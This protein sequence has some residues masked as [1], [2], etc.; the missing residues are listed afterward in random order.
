MKRIG[1]IAGL[2]LLASMVLA[3]VVWGV[4]RAPTYTSYASGD[5]F[6]PPY[7]SD[8]DRMGVAGSMAYY[9]ATLK[10]GWY[11]DWTASANPL[12][13]GGTE[14]ARTLYFNI[15]TPV[16]TCGGYR[17]PAAQRS[18]VVESIT[19][20]ALIDNLRANPGALWLIGNEPD[21]IYNG[22]PIMPELY[23]ELYHEFYTFI[24][25]YDPAAR[26]AIGA[27]VQPSPLR[28]QYLDKVLNRYE[29]LYGEK[30]PADVWNIHLYILNEGLCFTSWGATIPPG[31][32]SAGWYVPFT[33]AA[34]LNV[35]AMRQN[36]MAFR[37][38]M[39][40]RGYHARPLII[41]EFGV[42]PP[43]SYAGFE[44]PVAAQFLTDMFNM[45]LTA[46]DPAVGYAADG[47]R[48]VQLW[49]WYSVRDVTHNYGG[50]LVYGNGSLTPVGVAF[51]NM[52]LNHYTLA[53]DVY[54]VPLITP[55]LP[56]SG[57]DP[58]AVTL[59]VQVDNRGNTAAM[60]VP[61]QFKQY[62]I[63]SGAV[64]SSME[65]T[66]SQVLA[67]YAGAQPQ[68]SQSW[69]VTPGD[70]R[71]FIFEIDPGHTISQ[72]RRSSQVLAYPG[73]PDLI[74]SSLTAG[75]PPA[76]LWLTPIT[77]TVTATIRNT[78]I[79]TS[80]PA[81]LSLD[82]T[83]PSGLLRQSKFVL[84]LAPG[85]SADVTATLPISTSGFYTVSAAIEYANPES[86]PHNNTASRNILA[87][88]AQVY[89]PVVL[90]SVP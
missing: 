18:D 28:L 86:N 73:T 13:P 40:D 45:L 68:V 36:L 59:T 80:S 16:G 32:D 51:A 46:T 50:D 87:A 29:L 53:A 7:P 78:G 9:T 15:N 77:T 48:L 31:A 23:A 82:W 64:L 14:Y 24:K 21:S 34:L 41:T 55:A 57:S 75:V 89:L 62:D 54:P 60:S 72:A 44:E 37:Q 81:S 26:V 88:V 52:T 33:P 1:S 12:H 27:I 20:T 30:L 69:L 70:Q 10:A 8:A 11:A 22:S 56:V 5:F 84:S 65:V 74:V 49:T 79:V 17:N 61:V 4:A 6:F 38:W 83:G 25:T 58:A 35:N 66:L 67:R 76:F 43:P 2:A 71:L 3:G 47:N 85:A 42:L 39:A 90:R 63:P 19:G